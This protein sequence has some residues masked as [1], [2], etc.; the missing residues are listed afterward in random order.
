MAVSVV[1]E[2]HKF[3]SNLAKL[4]KQEVELSKGK[5]I[6]ATE[7]NDAWKVIIQIKQFKTD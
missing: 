7:Y 3:L 6:T 1:G 2:P 5:E 4:K